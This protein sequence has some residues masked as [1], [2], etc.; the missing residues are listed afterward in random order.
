[1]FKLIGQGTGKKRRLERIQKNGNRFPDYTLDYLYMRED[2]YNN[3][4]EMIAQLPRVVPRF[5]FL[6]RDNRK[7]AI[8]EMI[9]HFGYGPLPTSAP[10]GINKNYFEGRSIE[11]DRLIKDKN[12]LQSTTIQLVDFNFL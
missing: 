8:Y 7:N 1:M 5:N 11:L 2:D 9:C 3:L 6:F 10:V 4:S 12:I